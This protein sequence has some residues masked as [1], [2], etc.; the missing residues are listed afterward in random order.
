MTNKTIVNFRCKHRHSAITHPH[1]YIKY[2]RG[3]EQ[4]RLPKILLFDIETAPLKAFVFQKSVWKADISDDK[5]ISEWYTLCWSAKWLFDD[6]VISERLTRQ[7]VLSEDDSRIVND[8]W[9]LLDDADIVIAH[10]GDSFD[11]PNMNTRFIINELLPP[12]PYKTIDTKTIAKKQFGFTHNSLNALA[13]LF[14]LDPKLDVDFD[15]WKQCVDGKEKALIQM[16]DYNRHDVELLERVYLRLRPWIRSH[17][18][19][20]LYMLSDGA[21]CPNCGS[22]NITWIPNQYY[23]TGVSRFPIFRCDCGAYGRSRKSELTPEEKA[24]LVAPL[25]K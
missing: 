3:E 22:H 20:G 15:L 11:I 12:K 2:L 9:K 10:N 18:N 5:V 13:R 21:V 16:E 4:I 6:L 25:A 1:C 19:L 24:S 7:E 14:K 17:P 23:Y 8:L